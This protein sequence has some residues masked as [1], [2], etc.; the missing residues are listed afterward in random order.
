[1]DENTARF[2][3]QLKQDPARLQALLRSP[4]GQA[5]LRQLSQGGADD[6]LQRAAASAS[7]GNPAEAMKLVGQYLK[8]PDGAALAERVRKL[9]KP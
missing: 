6:S 8:T 4:D 2:A 1:M 5:L 3:E 7:R 9:F